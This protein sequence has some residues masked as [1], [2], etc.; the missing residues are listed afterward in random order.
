[1]S[2][3]VQCELLGLNRNA[4][5]ERAAESNPLNLE[6][7]HRLDKE[8]TTHPFYGSRR[9]TAVCCAGSGMRSIASGCCG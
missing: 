3:A 8:Y 2:L 1:M 4:W 9:M 7:M 6:L 5:Y